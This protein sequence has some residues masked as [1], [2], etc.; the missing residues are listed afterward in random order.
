MIQHKLKLTSEFILT[1]KDC[2]ELWVAV[3]L[4]SDFGFD[5]IQEHLNKN[6]TQLYLVGI[7]LPTSP[8]V[9]SKL[10]QMETDKCRSKIHYDQDKFFHPKVYIIKTGSKMT[11][12]VGSANCTEGGLAKNLE[13]TIKVEDQNFCN[14]LL[15]WFNSLF[16]FGKPITDDFL[17]TY[18]E[19]FDRRV[20]RVQQDRNELKYIFPDKSTSF[21]LD[22]IDFTNQF[23]KAYH[24][25]AFEGSKPLSQSDSANEE[26]MEVRK[27][28]FKLH[29]KLL[30]K[31]KAKQWDLHEHYETEH[32][33]SS[34]VHSRYTGDELGGIWLHY[35]RNKK[36]IK[37]YGEDETPLDYMRLQVIVHK[38]NIGIWNRVGKD[39]GSKIDR[40]NLQRK[41]SDTNYRHQ[42]YSALKSLPDNFFIMLNGQTKIIKDFSSEQELINFVL[43]D[44]RR[45]YFIIGTEFLPGATEL[46]EANIVDT[47]IDN[48]EKLYPIYEIIKHKLGL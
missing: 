34:A 7:G 19:L 28:L 29:D 14:N 25:N 39:N 1:L 24:Y 48:F 22:N 42:F 46:S 27:Q 15:T 41:L 4:M 13:L 31:I 44:N 3:A 38:D 5:F 6:A 16:K 35:G 18:S 30:P 17:K 21:N 40:D 20:E 45:F 23:F 47:V 26:R 36:E 37:K 10:K 32:I 2:D 8:N 11:A 9:L 43:K 33:V 12:Y